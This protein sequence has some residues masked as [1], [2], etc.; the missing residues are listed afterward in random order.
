MAKAAAKPQCRRPRNRRTR[1]E[2]SPPENGGP[3]TIA[4]IPMTIQK[5]RRMRKQRRRQR[6]KQKPKE[7]KVQ[8]RGRRDHRTRQVL[9]AIQGRRKIIKRSFAFGTALKKGAGG[10]PMPLYAWLTNPTR[11]CNLCALCPHGPCVGLRILHG[12]FD[13]RCG[14]SLG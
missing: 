6:L 4:P 10:R 12:F 14:Y 7:T 8:N 1:A 9:P 11:I 5:R 3:V 2:I 13:R